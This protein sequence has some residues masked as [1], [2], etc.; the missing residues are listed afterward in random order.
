MSMDKT[1]T[2][3]QVGR[4]TL[5]WKAIAPQWGAPSSRTRGPVTYEGAVV[6]EIATCSPMLDPDTSQEA[7]EAAREL[8]RLDSALGERL[9]SFSPILLRSEAASSSQIE[10]LTASARAVLG[11]ELGART[12]ATPRR[13]SP[14]PA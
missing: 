5:E 12:G 2:W 14:T 4:E 13:S 7:D 11:A 1:S 6:P 9:A 10:N 8:T 3:P